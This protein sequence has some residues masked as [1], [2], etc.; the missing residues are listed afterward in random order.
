[1]H[2]LRRYTIRLDGFVSLSAPLAGGELIT[3]PLQFSGNQ[4]LL[5]YATSAAGNLYVEILN[6]EG[7]PIPGFILAEADELFGDATEQV[8]TWKGNANVSSLMGQPVR[9]RFVLRDADLFSYQFAK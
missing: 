6:G 3:K 7:Q 4:L 9:L 8:V 2:R 5:N 1:M